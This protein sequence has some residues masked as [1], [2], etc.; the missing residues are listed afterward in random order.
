MRAH[1][2]RN[3][4]FTVAVLL[5]VL[6]PALALDGFAEAAASPAAP[7]KT[8]DGPRAGETL[9]A[10]ERGIRSV[11]DAQVAAWNRGDLDSFMQGY[12]HSP[13]LTFYSGGTVSTGWDAALARYQR[14]Y[15]GE[16]REMGTLDFSN[17]EIHSVG[18]NDAWVGGHWHLKMR[19]GKDLGGLFT[20]IFKKLP[21]GW[22]IVHDHTSSD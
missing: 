8:A 9:S 19:D 11:L 20:L 21:E 15:Q 3:M 18:N 13:E 1:A 10:A 6:A 14:R 2:V 22:K 5:T 12:W 16:G 4:R 7:A 17:L